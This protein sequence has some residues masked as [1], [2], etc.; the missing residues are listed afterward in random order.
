MSPLTFALLALAIGLVILAPTRRLFVAGWRSGPLTAYF[1]GLLLLG[2]LVAEFRG[3][4]RFLVPILVVAYI[5][6][7][8]TGREGISRLLGGPRG[9]SRGRPGRAADPVPPPPRNV[10]PPEPPPAGDSGT[11]DQR[12]G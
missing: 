4:A 9:G 5:A 8:M 1:V 12:R 6:P 2:L 11:G 7:F 3:P 10:T